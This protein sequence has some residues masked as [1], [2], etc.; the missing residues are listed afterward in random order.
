MCIQHFA[1]HKNSSRVA[2]LICI[3]F[4][5]FI[6]SLWFIFMRC[7]FMTNAALFEIFPSLHPNFDYKVNIF[8]PSWSQVICNP[9]K[10]STHRSHQSSNQRV[11]MLRPNIVSLFWLMEKSININLS[12][13]SKDFLFTSTHTHSFSISMKVKWLSL[14]YV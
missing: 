7:I 6:C 9:I 4:N 14:L 3:D 5:G 11:C 2:F 1:G 8:I 13:S 10:K 12:C